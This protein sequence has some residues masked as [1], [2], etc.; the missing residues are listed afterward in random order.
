MSDAKKPWYVV[1][2][3][4]EK[5]D[6]GDNRPNAIFR[7]EEQ[8]HSYAKLYWPGCYIIQEADVEYG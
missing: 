4:A 3:D 2:P 7:N 8:A 5:L 6:I 1:I